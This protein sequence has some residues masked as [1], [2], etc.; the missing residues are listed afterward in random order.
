MNL[1]YST[2][3]THTSTPVVPCNT[4]YHYRL[5]SQQ[6]LTSLVASNNN[7]F[8]AGAA[9]Q[10]RQ[11]RRPPDQ[12]FDRDTIGD[13][14]LAGEKPAYRLYRSM[15]TRTYG[16]NVKESCGDLRMTR[17]KFE[18]GGHI[19][20]AG[21]DWNKI[22]LTDRLAWV[23]LFMRFPRGLKPPMNTYLHAYRVQS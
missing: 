13:P 2:Q 15:P 17:L 1:T 6:I 21:V 14:L 22:R 9:E 3:V 18:R 12:C 4:Q 20:S 10:V 11:T 19:F 8:I 16:P 23:A 5:K 7:L